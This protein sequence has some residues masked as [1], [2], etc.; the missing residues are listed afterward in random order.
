MRQILKSAQQGNKSAEVAIEIFVYRIQ[1][2]I[3]AYTAVLI[4]VDAI[5]FT[6]GI[7]ENSPYLRERILDNFDY[8]GLKINKTKNERNE[9][10]FS[11]DDSKIYAMTI[12]TDEELVIAQQTYRLLAAGRS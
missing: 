1:K 6:A 10:V 7:G 9:T 4:G 5:V 12:P 8:L 2:Y 3:G 11:S